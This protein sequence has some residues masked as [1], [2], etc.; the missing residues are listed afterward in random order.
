MPLKPSERA[1]GCRRMWALDLCCGYGGWAE[2]LITSGWEVFGVDIERMPYS[3]PQLIADVRTLPVSALPGSFALVV[4]SPPC[5]EFSRHDQ[6]W[7]RA[8]D[9]P[10]PDL[11]IWRACERIARECGAPLVLENVRGAQKWVGRACR[12]WDGAYLWGEGVPLLRPPGCGFLSGR[13]KYHWHKDPRIRAKVPYEL[14]RWVG[15]YHAIEAE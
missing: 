10:P 1:E 3:G 15:D 13:K 14:A 11:S 12:S 7:T 6:P 5:E 9:P 8:K 2:G 4:A